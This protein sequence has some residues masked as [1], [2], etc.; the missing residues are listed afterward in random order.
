MVKDLVVK[1]GF[2]PLKKMKLREEIIQQGLHRILSNEIG[3][4]L[5]SNV[6]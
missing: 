5:T 1:L 4:R 6:M 3:K 2:F